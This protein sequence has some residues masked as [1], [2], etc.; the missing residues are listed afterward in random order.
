LYQQ[1]V[2]ADELWRVFEKIGRQTQLC[3]ALTALQSEGL[4]EKMDRNYSFVN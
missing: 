3:I 4:I 1:E 2:I